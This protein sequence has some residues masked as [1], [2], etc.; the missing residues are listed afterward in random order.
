MLRASANIE[1]HEDERPDR[2]DSKTFFGERF[3]DAFVDFAFELSLEPRPAT[4]VGV[5]LIKGFPDERRRKH[6]KIAAS[7]GCGTGS[8]KQVVVKWKFQRI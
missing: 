4:I 7:F 2:S 5:D 3:A 1:V 6:I 8:P